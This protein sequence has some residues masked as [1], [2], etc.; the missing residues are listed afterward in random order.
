MNIPAGI[1]T[2][3][4]G[5]ELIV[6][7]DLTMLGAGSGD[8][9]IEAAASPIDATSRVFAITAADVS[10]SDVTIRHGVATHG[11]GILNTGTLMFTNGSISN[12]KAANDLGG[13][14][15]NEGTLTVI[16]STVSGNEAGVKGGGVFNG[17]EATAD[18]VSSTIN[19]NS[20]GVDGGGIMNSFG[21]TL[22]LTDS[23]LRG[24]SAWAGGGIFSTWSATLTL[25]NSI[26][27]GN[28]AQNG[29]GIRSDLTTLTLTDTVVS[30]NRANGSEGG[31]VVNNGG[32]L[33]MSNSIVT[34]NSSSVSGGGIYNAEG[35]L[36]I[37][38]S[39][40]NGNN[41]ADK[42]GGIWNSGGGVAE[43]TNVT[44]SGNSSTGNCCVGQGGGGVYNND[45]NISLT[46]STI[47]ANTASKDGGGIYN[48]G[49]TITLT[50]SAISGNTAVNNSGGVFNIAPVAF[51]T[52][53]INTTV[54]GNT[55]SLD[56]G[57]I[58]NV[59]HAKMA[60]TNTTISN[61]TANFDGGGLQ[62]VNI[63]DMINSIVSGNAAPSNPDCSA[64]T[65]LGHNLIGNV[66]GC[67][68]NAATG[69]LTNV[70]PL[71]GLLQDNGGDT[72][73]H[74]L[75]PGSPAI[76]YIPVENCAV[77]TDQRGVSRPQGLA[78]DIGKY[79]VA[80]IPPPTGMVSWWPGDGNA[81]DII[82]GNDGT[83]VGGAGFA[84]GLVG[85]AFSFDASLD[86]GVIV[87][88]GANLNMTEAITLDAWI[89]PSSFPNAYPAVVRRNTNAAA[90]S[91]YNLAV[92]DQGEA[93]CNIGNF[94]GPVGGTVVLNEWTHLACVYDRVAAR[95]YVNGEEVAAAPAT[96][97]IPASSLPLGIGRV[98]SLTSRNFDG[99]IDE[100]EIFNRALSADEIRAIYEAGSGGKIK[101][102]PP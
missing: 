12:N 51:T 77:D 68:F 95:V 85:Q 49:G 87:P 36:T 98:E 62:N 39:T 89:K 42:G 44:I 40:I 66:S 84:P 32:R 18:I 67:S 73:T 45:G 57:G 69:D 61:N 21:A 20:T 25:A 70:D 52:T 43:L 56:G 78:C 64:F 83:L 91:Q 1:Y 79:E 28:E 33:E 13:G 15:Y 38:N 53:L 86:S 65:S 93:H 92:T 22:S 96:Q 48:F 31:G 7:E 58:F 29:G 19:D 3:T 26:V 6:D 34:G 82:D 76:D 23:V 16:A 74:A 102:P 59:G 27:T 94:V 47:S 37:T 10:L 11:G 100:V 17:D 5:S 24:N 14:I 88:N 41:A 71:L 35:T 90:S 46:N 101:L 50:E 55:A 30:H 80:P 63:V 54:S 97:P 4:L 81:E 9:I 75:L 8:T 2:L 72:F 99:L 60:L